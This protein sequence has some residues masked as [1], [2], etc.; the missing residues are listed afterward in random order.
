MKTANTE[1]AQNN[2]K[3]NLKNNYSSM[4][5]QKQEM[6]DIYRKMFVKTLKTKK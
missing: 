2:K 5:S 6:E 1:Q 3:E 4:K